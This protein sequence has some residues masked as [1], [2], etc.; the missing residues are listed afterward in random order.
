MK[1]LTVFL[2]EQIEAGKVNE[3]ADSIKDEKSFREYAEKKFKEAFGDEY[4]ETKMK[5]TVDGLLNDN[6][7]LVDDGKWG[8]LV[9]ML[10]KSFGK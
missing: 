3:G 6:K 7:E 9:G 4:D 1:D 5:E 2:T 8:E 10:N